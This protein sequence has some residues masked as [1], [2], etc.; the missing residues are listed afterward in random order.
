MPDVSTENPDIV[1]MKVEAEIVKNMGQWIRASF[2]LFD[3]FDNS[4]G[5]SA[6]RRTTG[7]SAGIMAH[8]AALGKT[9]MGVATPDCMLNL[10]GIGD[11]MEELRKHFSITWKYQSIG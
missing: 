4:T 5:L 6:M 1:W 9:K 8:L 2:T 10:K 11:Y 7:F 3:L